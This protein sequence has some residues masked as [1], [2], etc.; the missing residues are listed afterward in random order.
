MRHKKRQQ[1]IIG[2]RGIKVYPVQIRQQTLIKT[3]NSEDKIKALKTAAETFLQATPP[4]S[5]D[6]NV[7]SVHAENF[8]LLY[9]FKR[10]DHA[11]YLL[12]L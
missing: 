7:P 1:K 9:C 8:N 4:P 3:G 2:G 6:V 11:K 5:S 10:T 12:F